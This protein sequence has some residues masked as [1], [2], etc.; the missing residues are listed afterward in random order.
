MNFDSLF[1][2]PGGRTSRAH[3]VPALLTLLAVFAFYAFIVKGRT[4]QWCMVV[5][6]RPAG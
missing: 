1:A 2:G 3:F 5:L 4:A 6:L